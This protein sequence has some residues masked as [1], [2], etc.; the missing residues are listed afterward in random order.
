MMRPVCARLAGSMAALTPTPVL[1]CVC[2]RRRRAG[3]CLV[4]AAAPGSRGTD[5]VTDPERSQW[6]RQRRES[7]PQRRTRLL[8]E[9]A[10]LNER[11]RGGSPSEVAR[12][13]AKVQWLQNRSWRNWELIRQ[14]MSS[15][16][17]AVTLSLIE[18]ANSKVR[19]GGYWFRCIVPVS[20][21]HREARHS[22]CSGGCLAALETRCTAPRGFGDSPEVPTPVD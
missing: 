15:S 17:G 16:S 18:A 3:G 20:P 22:S 6:P 10:V 19:R 21:S 9:L 5:T 2:V 4:T 1:G 12:T 11:L 7:E 14:Y 8:N 13:R